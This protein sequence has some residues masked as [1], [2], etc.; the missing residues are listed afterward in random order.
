MV[1]FGLSYLYGAWLLPMIGML[2]PTR[3]NVVRT[4]ARWLYTRPLVLLPWPHP[5][6]A[7]FSHNAG[8]TWLAMAVLFHLAYL[9]RYFQRRTYSKDLGKPYAGGKCPT[10]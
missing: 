1:G 2:L 8:L 3:L 6:Q 5:I 7:A 9:L 4:V 10:K